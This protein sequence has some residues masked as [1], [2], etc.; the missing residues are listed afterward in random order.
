MEVSNVL[1]SNNNLLYSP[2]TCISNETF[3]LAKNLGV[4][5]L[6]GKCVAALDLALE[7]Q[8]KFQSCAMAAPSLPEPSLN[9][10]CPIWYGR[11]EAY[12]VVLLCC[13]SWC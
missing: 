2:K 9:R 13:L 1:F 3:N 12:M 8:C 6:R 5:F 7:K 10:E 4:L 11:R